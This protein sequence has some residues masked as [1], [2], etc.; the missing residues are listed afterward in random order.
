MS[1]YIDAF[2]KGYNISIMTYGQTGSGKTYTM[3][4]PVNSLN[5]KNGVDMSGNILPHYGILPRTAIHLWH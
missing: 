4:A 3:I 1:S 5:A 2:T